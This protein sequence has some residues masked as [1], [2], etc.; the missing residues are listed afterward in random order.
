MPIGSKDW[1][2]CRSSSSFWVGVSR[3]NTRP[4]SAFSEALSAVLFSTVALARLFITSRGILENSCA[5]DAL[6]QTTPS[7]RIY[8]SLTENMSLAPFLCRRT[9]GHSSVVKLNLGVEQVESNLPTSVQMGV[10]S[11]VANHSLN[12]LSPDRSLPRRQLDLETP[13]QLLL[14]ASGVERISA[15]AESNKR[16]RTADDRH[17]LHEVLELIQIAKLRVPDES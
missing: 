13:S 1:I 17:V 11:E 16:Q 7:K 3:D 5:R 12:P 9:W 2:P 8:A 10:R 6:Q 15:A 4:W 14:A